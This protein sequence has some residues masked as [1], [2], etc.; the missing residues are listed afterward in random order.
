MRM[1]QT[2]RRFLSGA[3]LAGAA[4]VLPA[5]RGR[6]ESV[7]ETT[8]VRLAKIPGVCVAPQYVAEELLREEGF[9]DI[10]YVDVQAGTDLVQAIARAE[11]DFSLSFAAPAIIPMD[12]GAPITVVAGVHVGCFELFGNEAIRSIAWG[13]ARMYSLR[14]W[15]P[16]SVSTRSRTLIGLPPALM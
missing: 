16:M 8:S 4:A 11:L 7:L 2:R 15:Q 10:L 6:A 12:A 5:R 13:P 1:V 9:T 3:A 14:P